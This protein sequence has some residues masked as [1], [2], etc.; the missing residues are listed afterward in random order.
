MTL[1]ALA[2]AVGVVVDDAIVVLENIERHREMGEGPR[3]AASKGTK[4]IA[5]AATAAT[6]S[7]AAVFLPVVFVK[8]LVGSF[9]ARVRHHGGGVGAL[10]AVRGADAHA[11]AGRAHADRRRRNVVRTGV[12]AES[13][14]GSSGS[15]PA[16]GA[17][18]TGRFAHRARVL[19]IALASFVVS[20]GF[21]S[22]L[23]AEFFPPSDEGRFFVMMETPPGTTLEGT[24]DRLKQAE[25]WMLGA[26]GG[27][28]ALR[29][30]RRAGPKA[31]AASTT[32]SSSRC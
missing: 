19:G 2:L 15:T 27:A 10:L 31:R 25:K 18:S 6:L 24:L 14:S 30:R 7:I 17:C 9:L 21:G 13:S 32:P 4:E 22:R 8:G 3:E 5:F 23:G 16:T 29:R 11:D 1:L 26:A 28:R 20:C 12:C